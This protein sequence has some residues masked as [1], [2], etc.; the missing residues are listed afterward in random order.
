MMEKIPGRYKK[1]MVLI[2]RFKPYN[3]TTRGVFHRK[4]HKENTYIQQ[5][6][7]TSQTSI[8]TI[9]IEIRMNLLIS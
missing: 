3:S 4:P 5:N 6:S 1:D 8:Q 9:S 2:W 7:M